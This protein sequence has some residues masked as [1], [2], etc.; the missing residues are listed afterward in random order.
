MQQGRTG[1]GHSLTP[2]P[3]DGGQKQA[4]RGIVSAVQCQRVALHMFV[5]SATPGRLPAL[6]GH[7]SKA[8]NNE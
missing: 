1:N 8:I 2:L 6:S 5:S 3:L 7:L 4:N